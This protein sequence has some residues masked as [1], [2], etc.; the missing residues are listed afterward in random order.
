MAPQGCTP[1]GDVNGRSR[2]GLVTPSKLNVAND[3]QESWTIPAASAKSMREKLMVE[4]PEQRQRALA[5]EEKVAAQEKV[6]EQLH[7]AL[8]SARADSASK[9]PK[10]QPQQ[11]EEKTLELADARVQLHQAQQLLQHKDSTIDRLIPQVVACSAQEKQNV[12]NL[13][14][15][16]ERLRRELHDSRDEVAHTKSEHRDAQQRL[17]A[18]ETELAR[19]LPSI[20]ADRMQGRKS[21]S[22]KES[23]QMRLD[24]E[25]ARA[26]LAEK[27]L[28]LHQARTPQRTPLQAHSKHLEL[29]QALQDLELK[30]REI[31][32]IRRELESARAELR[33]KH[34]DVHQGHCINLER[35]QALQED[36]EFKTSENKW[37]RRELDAARADSSQHLSELQRLRAE[38]KFTASSASSSEYFQAEPLCSLEIEAERLHK[39]SMEL[40]A[41]ELAMSKSEGFVFQNLVQQ[42]IIQQPVVPLR[43]SSGYTSVCRTST[44]TKKRMPPLTP[45]EQLAI[46]GGI[47]SGGIPGR[48]G[49]RLWDRLGF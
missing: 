43:C 15:E 28:E 30:D 37:L 3:N 20:I 35:Q 45:R 7:H 5:A 29:Q 6:I 39:R 14:A 18:S 22:P 34:Q 11:K 23:E 13:E 27:K 9:E 10:R 33:G 32:Q 36:L 4:L 44:V 19:I 26:E 17:E 8:A 48:Q 41:K 1:L 2:A 25:S 46:I 31:T 42:P 49:E 38:P 16:I 40:A 21:V 12:S 47:P 24:L